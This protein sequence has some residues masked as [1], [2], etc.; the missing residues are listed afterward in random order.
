MKQKFSIGT[1]IVNVSRIKNSMKNARFCERIFTLAEREYIGRK[2]FPE[3]TAAG[4]FA[5][6]EAFAKAVGTGFREFEFGEVEILNG[7]FGKP[8]IVLHGT[9]KELFG[10]WSFDV[11]IS[12]T[13]EFATAVVIALK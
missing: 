3:E 10:D 8:Y 5:A 12:H 2:K 13:A 11:S 4:R 1:D 9:A 6:K 7:E